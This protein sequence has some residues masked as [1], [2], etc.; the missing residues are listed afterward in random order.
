[1]V[2]VKVSNR[3]LDPCGFSMSVFM[4]TNLWFVT[5]NNPFKCRTEAYTTKCSRSF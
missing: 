2:C 1:M 3:F 5:I 4:V